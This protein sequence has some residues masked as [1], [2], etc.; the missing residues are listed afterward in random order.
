MLYSTRDQNSV[1]KWELG[2]PPAGWGPEKPQRKLASLKRRLEFLKPSSL[3]KGLSA[4]FMAAGLLLSANGLQAQTTETVIWSLSS[5]GT[6]QSSST[7]LEA[8]DQK[9]GS[10]IDYPGGVLYNRNYNIG[11]LYQDVARASGHQLPVGM[12]P[13][14][15]LEYKVSVPIGKKFTL[16]NINFYALGG[17]SSAIQMAVYY[18]LNGF[19]ESASAG[20]INYN[21][22]SF[23][24]DFSAPVTLLNTGSAADQA[25]REI[26]NIDNNIEVG[27][28]KTLTLRVYPWAGSENRYFASKQFKLT[29]ELEDDNSELPE[30]YSL[31]VSQNDAA[32]GAVTKTP[33]DDNYYDGTAV[34]LKAAANFGYKFVRW[35]D[36]DN[37]DALLSTDNPY[38]INVDGNKH[39]KAVFEAQTTYS[40]TLNKIGSNWGNIQL[41]PAPVDGKYEA[42]TEVT[43]TV[44]PNAVTA[45]NYWEDNS[46][47]TTRTIVMDGDKTLSATF[48]EIPFIVGWDFHDQ[49]IKQDL[50][51]DFYASTS[52]TGTISLYNANNTMASWLSSAGA[53][54]PL[55]PAARMW[56][57]VADF[58]A[59]NPRYLKAQF[60]T[61]GFKNIQVKS[62]VGASYQSYS[63]YKLQYSLDDVTYIDVASV[64]ITANYNSRWT[65]LNGVL[66][67]EAEG[68]QKVFVK[69]VGD[70]NSPKLDN[71]T[72][73]PGTDIEGGAFAQVFIFADSEA[74]DD[75]DAPSLVSVVPEEGS[76]TASIN[77]S[78][79]LTFNERVQPGTVA[80]TLNGETITGKYGAKSATFS[81]ERLSYNTSYTLTVP[82]GAIT[83]MAGNVYAGTTVQ[84]QTASRAEPQRKLF[85]AV[86][87]QDG[88]GDYTSIIDAIAGAEAGRT[89]PW[90]I[91]IKNG[92]YEG[93][94]DIPVNKPFIHLIGQSRDGVIITDDL[95]SGGDNA[96]PVQDGST[97]VVNS[98][99]CYFENLTIENSFGYQN[100]AGPQALALYTKENHFTLNNVY[101]RSYQDTYLTTR[102]VADRHYVRNSRIEG[103]VDFIYGAGDV[104]FDRDTISVNRDAGGYIVAPNHSTGTAWGY[105]FSN[106]YIMNDRVDNVITYFGRPWHESPKTVFINSTLSP[107]LSIYP[108]GWFYKMGAIPAVFADYN[109]M[110]ANGNPVDLNQRIEDY[111]Y[112]VKDEMGNVVEVV[113][114]KA[115]NRLTDEEAASYSYENVI[116]RSGDSWDPRLMT[117]AP[118]QPT[119]LTLKNGKLSWDEVPYSRMYIVFKN[120]QVIGYSL[121]AN[122]TEPAP[123]TQLMAAAAAAE[124]AYQ[125]QAVG[126]F[127]ALSPISDPAS[128]LPITGL[129]LHLTKV[130]KTVKLDWRT[131]TE[132][133]T[134][135]FEVERSLDGQHFTSIGQLS[136]A[137]NSTTQQFYS[138][139]DKAPASGVNMYR[140]KTVDQDG[141]AE[142]S[143]IQSIE[144]SATAGLTIYPNP[145]STYIVL[146][147]IAVGQSVHIY[148]VSGHQVISNLKVPSS[149]RVDVSSLSAGV[150]LAVLTDGHHKTVLRFIKK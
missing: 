12:N 97:M 59:G 66:P 118:Q 26:V 11:P 29:G 121:E 110:D 44:I 7:S 2:S 98:K 131:E 89:S 81:Y 101:L 75:H 85:D 96:L 16:K 109:T 53:Y 35:V 83:D 62:L 138:F 79:V 63:V 147:T 140:I 148:S 52:N 126:E 39:I 36:A 104:F 135:S 80:I 61:E 73:N 19:L 14:C 88:S 32:A 54:A 8:A 17:G 78:I 13:D 74:I 116:L 55:Y 150:Y 129:K 28:A 107:G 33:N 130:G 134:S 50:T 146:P 115:K 123:Q 99:D 68:Q 141:S 142:F 25:G 90:L 4:S 106:N 65:E 143:D 18:S 45:F 114:G 119:N 48:D 120:G 69:W 105:V 128:T 41:S 47:L 22:K 6:A 122:F 111:E 137:G 103:A 15:Y 100:L 60:S 24:N 34:S 149:G 9:V 93:H 40:L 57:P 108:K 56:T 10:L 144:L 133:R 127:G 76:S 37:N 46:T 84:F 5:D 139:T 92:V 27:Q 145:A 125:V 136:A 77:G 49:S 20:A 112:D 38:L 113:K 31:T 58:N 132:L 43:L 3:R 102:N 86:V 70:V 71:N 42:G 124:D 1:A 95:L 67:V 82:E 117:E 64:D 87:A 94:H 51:A 23:G 21:G 72:A 91:Y 30:S